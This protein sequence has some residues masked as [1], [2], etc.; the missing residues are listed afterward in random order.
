MIGLEQAIEAGMRHIIL[1]VV[2]VVAASAAIAA[3]AQAPAQKPQFEVASVKP[4]KTPGPFR[5]GP[6][7]NRFVATYVPFKMLLQRA[8]SPANGSG[9]LPNQ[10][11]GGQAHLTRCRLDAAC[12]QT[13]LSAYAIERICQLQQRAQSI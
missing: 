3:A 7:G 6:I 12:S 9:L 13:M 2:L 5:L 10:I 11:I 1:K 8:Y 4:S